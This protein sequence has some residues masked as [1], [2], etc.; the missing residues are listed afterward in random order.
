[1]EGVVCTGMKL[2]PLVRRI[3]VTKMWRVLGL[4]L[5]KTASIYGWKVRMF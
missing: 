2:G 4:L 1:M 5:K 3:R